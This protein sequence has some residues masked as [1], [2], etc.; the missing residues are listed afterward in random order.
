MTSSEGGGG[1]GG[2]VEIQNCSSNNYVFE[3]ET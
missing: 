3:N 2:G 1:V